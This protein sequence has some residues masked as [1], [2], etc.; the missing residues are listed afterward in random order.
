MKK[1]FPLMFALLFAN[2]AFAVESEA[3]ETKG[4]SAEVVATEDV[5]R[6]LDEATKAATVVICDALKKEGLT[7]A[8]IIAELKEEL[9]NETTEHTSRSILDKNNQE[10]LAGILIGAV[11]ACAICLGAPWVYTKV[12]TKGSAATAGGSAVASD[13]ARPTPPSPVVSTQKP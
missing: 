3:V 5:T 2:Q 12:K 11:G 6:D 10:L 8:Q 13:A 4:G 9:R 1:M 7:N